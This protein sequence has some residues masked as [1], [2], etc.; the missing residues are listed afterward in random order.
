MPAETTMYSTTDFRKNLKIDYEGGLWIIVDA[1]HVKP[2]K[3]VAFVKTRIK[4]MIDGRSLDINFRSGDKVGRPDV[5]ERSMQVL[6][7]DGES[8]HFMDQANYDQVEVRIADL[9]EAARFLKDG[10]EVDVLYYNG[11]AVDVTLPNFV[12]MV[13]TECEPGV[14]G[15]TAQGGTKPAT[16][17]TG[18]TVLVPL[19]V[20]QDDKIRVDT[21]TGEYVTRVK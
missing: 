18:A 12:E 21:R 3:G 17:E 9:G 4:N 20:E 16:L 19:F 6:Y 8:W 10:L 14:R 5:Q 15:D 7:S 2:G 11:R 1:Q 13:I